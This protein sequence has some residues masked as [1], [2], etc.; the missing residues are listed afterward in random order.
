MIWAKDSATDGGT[1]TTLA[2]YVYDA[3]GNRVESDLW[4]QASG[5]VYSGNEKE[6]MR[7]TVGLTGAGGKDSVEFMLDG[8]DAQPRGGTTDEGRAPLG[9]PVRRDVR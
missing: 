8:P 1:V 9:R 4:T 6:W 5:D 2:T 3:L 7:Q